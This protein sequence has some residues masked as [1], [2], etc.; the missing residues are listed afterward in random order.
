M[1]KAFCNCIAPTISFP[2]HALPN[3]EMFYYFTM[4]SRRILTATVAVPEQAF[5]GFAFPN[6]H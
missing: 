4:T 2:A 3:A 6:R 1:E 5:R